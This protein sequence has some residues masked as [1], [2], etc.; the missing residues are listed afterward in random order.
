MLG[1]KAK[2][3][4]QHPAVCLEDFVPHKNLYRQ[5]EAKLDLSFIHALVAEHYSSRGRPSIDP[6]V[7]FK[8]QLIMFFEDIRSERQLMEVVNLNLA[9]RWYVG[10]DLG[11]ALPHH[12][13]LSKIRTRYGLAVFERFF[14]HIVE[15]CFEAGLVWGEEL[16]FD[17]TRVQANASMQKMQPRFYLQAKEHVMNVFA[18]DEQIPPAQ[19]QTSNEQQ[20]G[21][22]SL[23]KRYGTYQETERSASRYHPL[24]DFRVNQ[25]DPD[26]TPLRSSG[27]DKP[28]CG[29]HLHYVVDGGK[30]RVILA[31]LVTPATITD[32]MPMLDLARWV[33]FRWKVHP[34]I[35]VG[36]TKYGTIA[37][38][39]EL[40]QEGIRAYLP[41]RDYAND[42]PFFPPEQF[43]YDAE[44][45][46]YICP[47]DQPLT[48]WT[49]KT[50]AQAVLYRADAAI[51]NA[52]PLKAQCTDSTSGKAIRRSW[53]QEELD[54]V[55]GYWDTAAYA[56]A[57]RKRQ[58]WVEPMFAE[59]KE[60]HHLWR[61]RLRRLEKVNIE[62][63]L[64][65]AG[66]NLKRLLNQRKRRPRP[67]PEGEVNAM[68][69]SRLPTSSEELL[70][71]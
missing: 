4:Q 62:A 44:R 35:A 61:F 60:W 14:E 7:F 8:L 53:F 50:E 2:Q 34:R 32:N 58:V 42:T 19:E 36:D 23:V 55:K 70:A 51:C 52:C 1:R 37:N 65:A 13:S 11:E 22:S 49:N 64:T 25:T 18:Q 21:A 69:T 56:K 16:Y 59:A 20:V 45:D 68:I 39:A 46:V 63:L 66:Q 43:H 17:G 6:V 15:R 40:E 10:Y 38:I 71:S 54:R 26:A 30:A 3:F 57:M 9:H 33:R 12:S 47:Q 67:W 29:Y 48:R 41:M 27:E 24:A 5:L 31:A 28:H